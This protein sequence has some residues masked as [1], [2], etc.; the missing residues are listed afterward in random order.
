MA[1]RAGFLQE[2]YDCSQHL[3]NAQRE[4]GQLLAAEK[5]AKVQGYNTS[6]GRTNTDKENEG[7]VSALNITVDIFKI[8][9]E[10]AA[11]EASREYLKMAIVYWEP[12]DAV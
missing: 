3:A 9:S 2:L 7:S 10:I 4:L 1:S 5:Q 11:L 8:R 6:A 12:A